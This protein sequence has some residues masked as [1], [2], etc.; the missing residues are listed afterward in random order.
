MMKKVFLIFLSTV[1]FSI[2][3]AQTFAQ[4]INTIDRGYFTSNSRVSHSNTYT[5]YDD[6]W[7]VYANSFFVFE[8]PEVKSKVTSATLQIELESILN[9]DP[10]ITFGVFDVSTSISQFSLDYEIGSASGISIYNDLGS[11]KLYN[12]V[13]VDSSDVG[14]ILNI[15]LSN[16]ALYDLNNTVDGLFAVGLSLISQVPLELEDHYG[17][18]FSSGAT[19]DY[20]TR[21]HQLEITSAPVPE[22]STFILLGAGIGWLALYRRKAKKQISIP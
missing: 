22:P 1:F 7:G 17:V 12:E 20:L 14:T 3:T 18:R 4:T 13:T 8:L 16:L 10:S 6:Y 19:G 2:F 9:P 15:T 11:G 21:T 5:G